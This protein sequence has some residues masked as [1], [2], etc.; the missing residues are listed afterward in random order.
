MS[1]KKKGADVIPL[2]TAKPEPGKTI[3]G[4]TTAEELELYRKWCRGYPDN[5]KNT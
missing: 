1:A 2:P 4:T 5:R 3:F